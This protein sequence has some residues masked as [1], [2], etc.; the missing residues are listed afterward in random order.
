MRSRRRGALLGGLATLAVSLASFA[1]AASAA[2][3]A[4]V[5]WAG[6]LVT[7]TPLHG[8]MLKA[9]GNGTKLLVAD[10]NR[11]DADVTTTGSF[12]PPAEQLAAIRAAAKTA[13]AA[14]GV[15]TAGDGTLGSH[16]SYASATIEIGGATRTLVGLNT[17]SPAL[18][19]LLVEL[20]RAL[21]ASARLDDPETGLA[22]LSSGPSTAPCPPGQSPT[23]ISRRLPLSEAAKLGAVKLTAKGGFNGD[24]VAVDAT[25]KPSKAPVTVQIDIEV[26]TYPGGPTAKQ[27]EAAIESRLPG[28]TAIDGTKVKFDV[29]ARERAPGGS[30]SPCFHQVELLKD[31]KYR[32]EA[33]DGTTDPL[34]TP[35]TGQWPS[36][37]KGKGDS[38]IWT[39]EA[40]HLA[41]LEDQYSSFFRVGKKT[42]PIPDSVD[43]SDK[44]ELAEWAKSQKLDPNAGKL[45]TKA[46]KGHEQDIMGD[47]FKGTEKLQQYAVD[48]LAAF[49]AHRLTIEGKPGDLLLN[50]DGGSQ[51]LAVGAPFELTVTPGK[52]AHADGLVAYC[53]DLSRHSPDEGQGFDVLGL[54]GDQPQQSMQYLQRVLDVAATLQPA[55][56]SETPGAQDAVWRITDDSPTEDGLA[57]LAMAGV[58]DVQFSAPHFAN[59]NAG[60]PETRAVSE[61]GVE[62]QPAPTP[63]LHDLDVRPGKVPAGKATE[64]EVEVFLRAARD[65]VRFELQRRKGG[66]W[67]RVDRLGARRLR[68]GSR[69]LD[70]RLPPQRPGSFRLIAIG[71]ASSAAAPLRVRGG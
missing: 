19:A 59:P 68:P 10:N 3:P 6:P 32:G 21:P 7:G 39:H 31:S 27:V 14:P 9:S 33:G 44:K 13:F 37:R 15:K 16:G 23:T 51:N 53:I 11:A 52:K 8:V 50:K 58:P 2:Q 64:V 18:R 48:K 38:Q 20:N 24:A 62:P 29:V 4:L 30:P 66:R 61:T 54:A 22:Q 55:A 12:S 56:L 63:F 36:G 49:G 40:L 41:G 35:Q 45:F 5:V 65:E 25:W 34:T 71:K 70:L 69:N 1:P 43:A 17:S 47:V 57:I 28:R 46:K 42:I 26:S 60:S 67:L